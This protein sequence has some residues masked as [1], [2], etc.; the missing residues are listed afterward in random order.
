[1]LTLEGR[2][3]GR[4][5]AELRRAAEDGL[6]SPRGLMLDLA[7]VSFLDADGVAL[8]RDLSDRGARLVNASPFV[9]EQLRTPPASA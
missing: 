7:G 4:W 8:I 5:V 1:M 9:A 3:V 6:E 2:V